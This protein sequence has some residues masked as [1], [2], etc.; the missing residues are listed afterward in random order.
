MC[1][2]IVTIYSHLIWYNRQFISH[3]PLSHKSLQSCFSF[4]AH[5]LVKLLTLNARKE[6]S[7]IPQKLLSLSSKA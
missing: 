3:F 5:F 4:S 2:C 6:F 1:E 7:L